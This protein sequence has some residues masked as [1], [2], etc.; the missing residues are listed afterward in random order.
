ML[1]VNAM[2]PGATMPVRVMVPEVAVSS[3]SNF[4]VS[5]KST[6]EPPVVCCQFFGEA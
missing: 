6:V 4:A 5:A 2:E 1:F 3:K